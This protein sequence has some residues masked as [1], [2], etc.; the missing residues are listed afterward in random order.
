MAKIAYIRCSTEDQNP[1]RQ[2]ETMRSLGCVK[3]FTDMLSGKDTNRPGLQAMLEKD[4][5]CND[6]LIQTSAVQAAL[7]SPFP[8]MSNS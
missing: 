8:C 3:V 4:A 5:Y 2:E 7:K 6:I 1:A